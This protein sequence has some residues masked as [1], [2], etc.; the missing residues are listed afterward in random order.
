MGILSKAPLECFQ[1]VVF[2]NANV[3]FDIKKKGLSSSHSGQSY[4]E[5]TY[6]TNFPSKW[7][8]FQSN[9]SN[10]NSIVSF[11]VGLIPFLIFKV[12]GFFLVLNYNGLEERFG[13]FNFSKIKVRSINKTTSSITIRK[14]KKRVELFLETK[15]PVR[16]LGPLK[17][18]IMSLEVFECINASGTVKVYHKNILLFEDVYQNAGLEL[19]Y[20]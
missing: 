20:D 15:E 7:I 1:E 3:T 11:S 4:M 14:G 18:G 12:K 16:L 13:S 5:R 8:W 6:G 19:M 2:L 9:Y 17:N 10:N